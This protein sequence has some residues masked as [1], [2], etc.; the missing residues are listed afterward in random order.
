MAETNTEAESIVKTVR[1]RYHSEWLQEDKPL[2][3]VEGLSKERK[4]VSSK[5]SS[6]LFVGFVFILVSL[7]GILG[8]LEIENSW[9][10]PVITFIAGSS[11]VAGLALKYSVKD[12]NYMIE[13]EEEINSLKAK[14]KKSDS[15]NASNPVNASIN[16]NIGAYGA[17]KNQD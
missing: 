1:E 9:M 13:A 17:M 12:I 3:P 8:F 11:C 7:M 10:L 5:G 2:K 15:K 6:M 4:E 16:K 14:L